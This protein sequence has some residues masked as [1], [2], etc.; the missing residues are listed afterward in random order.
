MEC[1]KCKNRLV[2][3]PRK[4]DITIDFGKTEIIKFCF[5][6]AGHF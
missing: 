5:I 2:A 3:L 6:T 1:Q 4:L